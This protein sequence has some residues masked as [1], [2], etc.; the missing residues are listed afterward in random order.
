[1]NFFKFQNLNPIYK[2][3]LSRFHTQGSNK[4]FHLHPHNRIIQALGS[5]QFYDHYPFDPTHSPN[6][7]IP[8][9]WHVGHS[10]HR[11][12]DES[13]KEAENI[14]RLGL[15]AD[16]GLAAGKA[17]TGYL[18][19]STA[20]I[21]DAAHSASDVVLSGVALL[22]F[23]VARV[24]KDKEHPYGHGKFETL[25]ALGISVML[26][27]TAGG[28]AWHALDILVGL[29]SAPPEVVSQSLGH[30][31]MHS[32]HH[33]GHHHGIDMDHP[34]LALSMTIIAISVK[35]GLFWI[36][37]RAGEREGSGL[38]KANA[39]H[40]RADAVSSFVTLIGVGGSILGVKFLDPLAGIIVSGMI[41]KAGLETGYQSILE[42]V[43]A[44]VPSQQLDLYKQT[45]LQV[46]GVKG[47][48]HLRGRRAG[49]SLHL[50]VNI[51]VDPFSSVSAAHDVGESV[52]HHIQKLHHEVAEV[53]IHIDPA[54][55]LVSE[56][57]TDQQVNTTETNWQSRNLSSDLKDIE[58]I[59]SNILSSKFSE[60]LVLQRTTHHLLGDKILL[61]IEVSM[62]PDMSI[63]DAIKVAE[64]A[65]REILKAASDAVQVFIL[66]RLGHTIPEYSSF[67]SLNV[68]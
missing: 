19:G 1:M 58:D 34:I 33:G 25:G 13:S 42:L 39:W 36:T 50:D 40:H 66:L 43:D 61:Q 48:N 8:K 15:A 53:F 5:S 38:M 28:I 10:H 44:A 14:F 54:I 41:L 18:S 3:L 37:K 31:H 6:Y 20:I 59:V 9:R 23:K 63:R 4:N 57:I 24:P 60:K 29:L 52:R 30:E 49:S 64:E 46:E 62:P 11:R 45:I 56:S 35:E 55:S 68:N 2:T 22:S 67:K 26:L 27:G 21:A 7:K 16:F 47:C 65:E 32:H 51:E 17:L 12:R